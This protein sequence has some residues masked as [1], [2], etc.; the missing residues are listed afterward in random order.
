VVVWVGLD[1]VG[2]GG[3]V[4]RQIYN[5]QSGWRINKKELCMA[6]ETAVKVRTTLRLYTC[7][8]LSRMQLHVV[9]Y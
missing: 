2:D 5:V 1:W 7:V 9:V 3:D 4:G 6:K 8:W